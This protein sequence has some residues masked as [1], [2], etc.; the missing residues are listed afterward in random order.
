MNLAY[1]RGARNLWIVNVG[2]IKPME[3]PLSFFMRMA[4][5]PEAMTPE[6]LEA[7]PRN[8]PARP[9]GPELGPEIGAV[10]APT[11]PKPRDE[12]PS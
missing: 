5:N 4:W 6:A 3:Y 8:G 11:G 7:F 2:D 1:E 10:M 9:S 12:S